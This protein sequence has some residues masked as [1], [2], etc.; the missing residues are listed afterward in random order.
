MTK[1]NQADVRR[2]SLTVRLNDDEH[3]AFMETVGKR[4]S[5]TLRA[6]INQYVQHYRLVDADLRPVDRVKKVMKR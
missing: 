2:N 1:K 5:D 3:R 6:L 4:Y